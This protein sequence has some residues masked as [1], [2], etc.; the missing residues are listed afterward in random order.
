MYRST[1]SSKQIFALKLNQIYPQVIPGVNNGHL[2][3]Y[4]IFLEHIS[5][6]GRD[7]A[8][9]LFFNMSIENETLAIVLSAGVVKSLQSTCDASNVV[10]QL[11]E[12]L[13]LTQEAL[14]N[15]DPE[16]TR[17]IR[18]FA[19]IAKGENRLDVVEQLRQITPA[20]TTGV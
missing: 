12:T 15:P 3:A 8:S 7:D 16:S 14:E 11:R 18:S 19:M 13:E 20:G 1:C 17:L 5:A 4:N 2:V 6:K 10:A 9:N